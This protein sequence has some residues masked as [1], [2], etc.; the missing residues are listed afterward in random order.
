MPPSFKHRIYLPEQMD[1]PDC[2]LQKLERTYVQLAIINRSLSRMTS[3]LR[4]HVLFDIER[5]GGSATIAEF[6]CGGGDVLLC[7]A[8][9]AA[10]S[11][12]KINLVGIDSDPRA[13][14]RARANLHRFDKARVVCGSLDDLQALGADYV[15][16]NHVLHHI[17]PTD[18]L[19]VLSKLR[20]ACSRKLLINDLERSAVSYGLYTALAF[21]AFH[22]SYVFSDGRLSI[23]K[24]FRV[25]ELRKACADAGYPVQTLVEGVVPWRVV[26]VAP[27]SARSD[28]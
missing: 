5:R 3:L 28:L 20:A 4:K 13:V 9:Q 10:R 14:E 23:R 27:G 17:S 8:Q 12:L 11:G 2:D 24:G 21:V 1:A 6:G 22:R 16:S 7:L 19:P 25:P 26:I 15:F 18:L